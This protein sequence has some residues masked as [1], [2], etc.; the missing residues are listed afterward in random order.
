MSTTQVEIHLKIKP[1]PRRFDPTCRSDRFR[2]NPC[3]ISSESGIFHKKPI[4]SVRVFVGF[5][6]I[7]FLWNSTEPDAIRPDPTRISSCSV[8]FRRNP[9]RNPID[10]NP[11]KTLTDPIEIIQI[12]HDPIPHESPERLL[13][14]LRVRARSFSCL[15]IYFI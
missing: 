9:G 6:S 13:D 15:F 12:R 4:G 2:S 14:K 1:E 11:T 5:P 3:R 7:G 8:K 10:G